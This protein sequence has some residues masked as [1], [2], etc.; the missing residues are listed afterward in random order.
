MNPPT[1]SRRELLARAGGGFGMLALASM[2]EAAQNP[3]APRA[4][5]QIGGRAKSIIWIFTNGGPSQVDTWDHKPELAR[6]DGQTLEG[7]DPKTGF[8]QD[9]SAA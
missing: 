9:P 1:L 7:F 8:S 4:P 6:R 3:F 2:L 5:M